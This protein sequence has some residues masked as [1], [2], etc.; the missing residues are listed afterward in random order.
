MRVKFNGFPHA[1]EY[2]GRGGTWALDEVK[3][4]ADD[5]AKVLLADFAAHGKGTRYPA[6]AVAGQAA[7]KGAPKPAFSK[8]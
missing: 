5:D 6:P 8:A 2:V 7:D 4:I 3:D 1:D